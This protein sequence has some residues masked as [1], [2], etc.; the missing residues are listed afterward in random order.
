GTLTVSSSGV[1]ESVDVQLRDASL[2]PCF[3]ADEGG[4]ENFGSVSSPAAAAEAGGD[5]GVPA[6]RL[7][8]ILG[9]G[10]SALRAVAR[11]WLGQGLVTADSRPL[12]EP[13]TVQVGYGTVVAQAAVE[14][15][16]TGVTDGRRR[17]SS[18]LSGH[19]DSEDDDD[20]DEDDGDG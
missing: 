13:F 1:G 17:R 6:Q 5:G 2:L 14:G 3:Y 8:L 15:R 18:A 4:G 11:T 12:L 16:G 7:A 19:D 10:E 20:D 9:G